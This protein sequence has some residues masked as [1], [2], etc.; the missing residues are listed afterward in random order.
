MQSLNLEILEDKDRESLKQFSLQYLADLQEYLE[1]KNETVTE[2]PSGNQ[3]NAKLLT[4]LATQNL[5][6]SREG[7]FSSGH[8]SAG[9][10][11]V[12]HE[13]RLATPHRQPE[14]VEPDTSAEKFKQNEKYLKE[15]RLRKESTMDLTL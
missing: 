2:E 8:K 15:E 14:E 7:G 10:C 5:M 12:V 1:L 11:A 9:N 6:N 4:D 13:Q 3:G